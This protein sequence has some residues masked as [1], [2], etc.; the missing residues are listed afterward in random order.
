M[1]FIL[2]KGN[3]TWPDG[4]IYNGE[5]IDDIKNG[6]GILKYNDGRR[7]EGEWENDKQNGKGL[8]YFIIMKLGLYKIFKIKI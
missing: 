7:Y 5:F 6:F 8:R 4:Y 1:N 2:T 3:F